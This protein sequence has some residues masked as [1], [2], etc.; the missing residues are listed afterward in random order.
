MQ[1]QSAYALQALALPSG[2]PP[3]LQ[4][5]ALYLPAALQAPSPQVQ[6]QALR[7]AVGQAARATLG[8]VAGG[9]QHRPGQ[10]PHVPGQPERH[11]S[12]A[13]AGPLALWGVCQ[14][15]RW[16][17][18]VEAV[19]T[20]DAALQSHYAD[21]AALYLEPDAAT[22]P[23]EGAAFAAQWCALEAQLKCAGLPLTEVAAR[24]EGWNSGLH[25]AALHLPEGW[26]AYRA[27]IAC[28]AD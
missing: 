19:P 4:L 6:R 13:Y 3:G 26:G 21:V 15:A 11:W 16:G 2:C 28:R 25:T 23:L 18:D 8:P 24:P 10:A 14:E 27:A 12:V 9:L 1:S 17:V 20:I 22:A 5:F 7:H